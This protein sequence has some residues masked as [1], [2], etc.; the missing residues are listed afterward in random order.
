MAQLQ[1]ALSDLAEQLTGTDPT[2]ATALGE[3]VAA[4]V[5]EL[6]EAELTARPDRRR[7]G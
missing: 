2:L 5:Q 6:I 1:S 3:I 7:T 4:A